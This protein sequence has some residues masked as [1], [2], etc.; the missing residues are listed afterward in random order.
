[1]LKVSCG[2]TGLFIYKFPKTSLA[3]Q[4]TWQYR[5]LPPPGFW[6]TTDI[7][8]ERHIPTGLLPLIL[9]MWPKNWSGS[10]S[11]C[12]LALP[13]GLDHWTSR[14]P[15]SHSVHRSHTH[16]EAGTRPSNLFTTT[17]LRRG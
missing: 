2:D 14:M 13:L 4:D 1:M 5:L 6:S 3:C 7:W 10:H 9:T 15:V 17:L 12:P 11:A 16:A 8:A